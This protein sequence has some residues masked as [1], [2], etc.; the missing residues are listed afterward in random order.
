IPIVWPEVE[1]KKEWGMYRGTVE[2][3]DRDDA[4]NRVVDGGVLSN[5][6]LRYLI[7]PRHMARDGVLGQPPRSS[8]TKI[9]G[10]LLDE[11][12]SIPGVAPVAEKNHLADK[13]P[14]YRSLSRVLNAMSGAIDQEAIDDSRRPEVA[15]LGLG[16][17]GPLCRI[18]VKGYQT[19]DFDMDEGR[20]KTL[21][22]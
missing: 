2:M 5:F 19:L 22:Q 3:W 10:L 21:I 14:A 1:W 15:A 8:P 11:S 18:P 7:E 17:D 9:L 20:M 13:P 16:A 4:G 12:L 6:P